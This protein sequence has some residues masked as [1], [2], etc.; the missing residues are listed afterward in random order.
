MQ[1]FFSLQAFIELLDQT[2]TYLYTYILVFTLLACGIYFSIRTRFIQFRFLSQVFKILRE[3]SHE[4]HVSPFGALMISTASR[5]GI[6]NIVGVS[7]A[8]SMGGVGALFWMWITALLGGASAFIESTL[9]Q[10]YK[11]KDGAYNYKGGPAYYIQSAL[12]SR[13]FGIVFAI[14]LILCF[15]YGFNGLQSYTLTSAFE[16]YIGS[17]SF[18]NGYFRIFLG[19]LLSMLVVGFFYGKNQSC[20]R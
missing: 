14:S 6:G 10:V 16:I 13:G 4:E 7:V 17:D 20:R 2:N 12:G 1:D 19:I 3:K 15:T 18:Q 9:A 11:R 8:M 5:V